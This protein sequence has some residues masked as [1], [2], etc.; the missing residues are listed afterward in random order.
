MAHSARLYIE[1]IAGFRSQRVSDVTDCG[2]VRQHCL[3]VGAGTRD[4]RPSDLRTSEGSARQRHNAATT[5]RGLA[6]IEWVSDGGIERVDR[7]QAGGRVA[8]PCWPMF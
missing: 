5:L 1:Q 3:P 2:A 7:G 8:A 6:E 4:E